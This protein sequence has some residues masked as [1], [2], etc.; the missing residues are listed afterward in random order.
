MK[1][2][3]KLKE[4]L[5]IED[6]FYK[7][8]EAVGWITFMCKA[9]RELKQEKNCYGRRCIDCYKWLQ[10][11]YKEP[12]LDD[13]EREYLSAVIKPF[14]NEVENIEKMEVDD[15]TDRIC[16]GIY[17]STLNDIF[18]PPFDK[19]TMYRGMEYNVYTLE[20]LDL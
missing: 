13:V 9:V 20:E 10:Q 6:L 3:D 12:I 11:E 7:N 14:R 8:G 15:E 18:L 5:K 19:G 16:I 17:G 2:F 4:N 1:N